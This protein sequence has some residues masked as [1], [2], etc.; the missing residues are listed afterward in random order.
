MVE[1]SQRR[2]PGVQ[3]QFLHEPLAQ[4]CVLGQ[5]AVVCHDIQ[6]VL[7]VWTLLFEQRLV[8]GVQTQ[9]WQAPFLQY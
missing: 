6:S 4:V 1:P 3:R 8:P 9:L 7:Q 5:V 2:A